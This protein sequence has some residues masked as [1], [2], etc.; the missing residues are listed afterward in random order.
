MVPGCMPACLTQEGDKAQKDFTGG[1]NILVG[2]DP[3]VP[4]VRSTF[5]NEISINSTPSQSSESYLVRCP[6]KL[7]CARQ[8]KTHLNTPAF[9][10]SLQH[11]LASM[12]KTITDNA[13]N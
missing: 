4:K 13:T 1:Y 9:L 7:P 5:D 11:I 12:N 3:T 8:P 6:E 10:V 2:M